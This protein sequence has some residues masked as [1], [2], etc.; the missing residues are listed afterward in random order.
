MK[1]GACRKMRIACISTVF[2]DYTIQL[3]NA[4]SEKG[5][6]VF[7]ILPNEH[8]EDYLEHKDS[9]KENVRKYIY[10]QPKFYSPVNV[11][12]VFRLLRQLFAF[13]PDI[14]HFQAYHPWLSVAIPFLKLKGYH[15]VTTF[16]DVIP[17]FGEKRSLLA[18]TLLHSFLIKKYSERIFVHGRKLKELLLERYPANKICIIPIGEH[19]A[20]P[21]KKYCSGLQEEKT[22]VLFFGRIHQYK[23]LKYLIRAEPLIT[24]EMPGTKIVIA[25]RGE[26]FEEYEGLMVNPENFIVHNHFIGFKQAAELF[27]KCSLVVLPYVD[28]SQ[29]GVVPV[30]YAFKKPVVVTNVGS[31]PE[32][33]D[34]GKTGYV[35]KAGDE[36][37]LAKSVVRLLKDDVLR[38]EL[39]ENGYLKLKRDLSWDKIAEKTI[40]VYREVLGG[41]SEIGHHANTEACATRVR[42]ISSKGPD[43][44]L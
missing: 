6:E 15:T 31:L 18:V 41:K 34:D 40:Q 9:I 29:S 44:M 10:Y 23:G 3:A 7:V 43:T 33:V 12:L 38:R 26:N 25:G 8:M 19:N 4:L 35:V 30:A 42:D 32:I 11:L 1:S 16:H 13:N 14:I 21:L 17:H 37:A 2:I 27:E 36:V 22:L 28:A 39:G 5:M 24:K 20:A